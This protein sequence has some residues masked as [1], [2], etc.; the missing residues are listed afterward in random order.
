MKVTG[1]TILVTT[2]VNLMIGFHYTS[3]PTEMALNLPQRIKSDLHIS[4]HTTLPDSKQ[5]IDQQDSFYSDTETHHLPKW[6]TDYFKWHNE[7]RAKYPG[8]TILEDPSAPKILLRICIDGLCGGLHDRLGQLP[9]DLY[10]ANQTNRM[11]FIHW[12]KPFGLDEFLV[13]PDLSG[14][15]VDNSIEYSLDWRMPPSKKIGTIGRRMKQKTTLASLPQ[16]VGNVQNQRKNPNQD[17][18]EELIEMNIQNLTEGVLKNETVVTYEILGTNNEDYL[19][20]KL[21]DLGE[22]DMIHKTLSFGKI[23]LSFFQPSPNVMD[24]LKETTSQA[25]LVPY[26]YTAV[27]CRVRHPG[28]YKKAKKF[29]GKFAGTADRYIPEFSGEFK[30]EMAKSAIRAIQCAG[31][32][33]GNDDTKSPFYFMSDMS[34][35]VTYMAFNL[36]NNE[37]TSSHPEWFLDTKG[38]NATAKDMVSKHQIVAR[39]QLTQNL[40]IDKARPTDVKNYYGSFVDLFIGTRAR[41]VAFGI[42]NYARFAAKISHT[43]CFV[44]YQNQ[45]Y[46]SEEVVKSNFN[47]NVEP[48]L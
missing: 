17:S 27:H 20:G 32:L 25:G 30:D 41:C 46:G 3:A 15:F 7:I 12:A 47:C 11:L 13:P 40:H 28:G 42:G 23:F 39:E 34:D 6:V 33:P 45:K 43:Q 26:E 4:H 24:V 10:I 36:T 35:L 14:D 37:Y 8:T 29:G 44:K 19:E 18:F 21:R 2:V 38:A 5:I 22:T 1:F 31:T 48:L 16:L 9:M